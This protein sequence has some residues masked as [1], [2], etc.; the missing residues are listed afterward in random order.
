VNHHI[1]FFIIIKMD[2]ITHYHNLIKNQDY[3]HKLPLYNQSI[4][5][6]LKLR[7]LFIKDRENENLYNDKYTGLIDVFEYHDTFEILPLSQ[8]ETTQSVIL[9]K[10]MELIE[11]GTS[12]ISTK[13][14]FLDN[15][16]IFTE[17]LLTCLDW[18]N[19]L[20]AGGSA[21]AML[22]KL[23]SNV[24]TDEQKRKYYHDTKYS[25]SDI[26]LYIYGLDEYHATQKL[27][28][29]YEDIKKVLS[30]ECVCIRSARAITIVSQYPYR[31]IQIVIRLFK[32]PAEVLHSFDVDSCSVGFDGRDV[33]CTP[34]AHYAITTKRNTVDMTRRSIAYEFRLKKYN[35]RGYGVVV[36]GFDRAKVNYRIFSKSP[37]Q[38]AG[39]A[40]LLILENIDNDAKHNLYRDVLNMHQC[41][42]YKNLALKSKYEV[43][44]YS[45][46]FLP[47]GQKWNAKTIAEHMKQKNVILNK[48]EKDKNDKK[49]KIPEHLCFV[50]TMYQ[51]VKDNNIKKPEFDDPLQLQR[52]LSK[53]VC[54]R[55]K[56][57]ESFDLNANLLGSFSTIN[58]NIDEW[59][60]DAYGIVATDEL[61]EYICQKDLAQALVLIIEIEE[62]DP[63]NGLE[64]LLNSRDLANRNPLH[65]AIGMNDFE[66]CKLLLES[67]ADPLGTGKLY[68]TA[69]HKACEGGNLEIVKLLLEYCKEIPDFNPNMRDS[70]G[71]SPTMYTIMYGHLDCFQYLYENV[72]K[73]GSSLVWVFKLDKTKSYRALEMCL[74]YKR[75]DIAQ[76]L[77][78]NGYDKDD[79]YYHDLKVLN[80]QEKMRNHIMKQAILHWDM[81]FIKLLLDTHGYET[82]KTHMTCEGALINKIEKSKNEEQIKYLIDMVAYLATLNKTQEHLTHL[83]HL[84][85]K[86]NNITYIKYLVEDKHVDV[87]NALSN[88]AALDLVLDKMNNIHILQTQNDI[89]NC[90]HKITM[91]GNKKLINNKWAVS[92]DMFSAEFALDEENEWQ[93]TKYKITEDEAKAESYE[94]VFSELEKLQAYLISFN[95]KTYN[96]INHI[97]TTTEVKMTTINKVNFNVPVDVVQFKDLDKNIMYKTSKYIE[98][99]TAIKNGDVNT[100]I[101]LTIGA[102]KH[103]ALHL[104]VVTNN[105]NLSP[106]YI[107]LLY[108][109]NMVSEI[110]KIMEFQYIKPKP[111]K[112]K[113]MLNS[114]KRI[115]MN[116]NKLN[117]KDTEEV[118][119]NETLYE[120]Q[121]D[122][123]NELAISKYSLDDLL[124]KYNIVEYFST[125][126]HALKI[127]L[128]LNSKVIND[129][130]YNR[131]EQLIRKTTGNLNC[132]SLILNH[133]SKLLDEE[134]KLNLHVQFIN[135]LIVNE[136]SVELYH[137][138]LNVCENHWAS[139]TIAYPLRLFSEKETV[140]HHIA[141]NDYSLERIHHN[142]TDLIKEI[143]NLN[144]DC[145]NYLDE[146][147]R[148]PIMRAAI[149]NYKVF[150]IL[151]ELQYV[152]YNDPKIITDMKRLYENKYYMLH[153]VIYH[154]NTKT[155]NK[156]IEVL[157]ERILEIIDQQTED[158]LQTPLMIGIKQMNITM[159]N[160]LIE[161]GTIQDCVDIFGNTAL[162]YAMHYSAFPIVK[163]LM[164]HGKE[165]FFRMTPQDYIINMMRS[166]FHH[167]R[168]DKVSK[169]LNPKQ[170]Y[171]IIG[172]YNTFIHKKE[173][174]REFTADGHIMKVNDFIMSKLK[175]I[176]NGE[177]PE[178]LKL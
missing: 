110:K 146:S 55:L 47:W 166:I 124:Q 123:T 32:S 92:T 74:L 39:L 148:T 67:G 153:K 48:D 157:G 115:Y 64:R 91:D 158:K 76:Y 63:E 154:N 36:P 50:G 17:G 1:L 79:Y 93:L 160:K 130:V 103:E 14:E 117:E 25:K 43:S 143:I 72:V 8:E 170:L 65:L 94:K 155:F 98:L 73:N 128:E 57:Y 27:Y 168:N 141:M 101:A 4:Q 16:E 52:Y 172:I 144:P 118:V 177:I 34:R 46:I 44:D 81:N 161:L 12:A 152:D 20:L 26:D 59:Y 60:N 125:N 137:Y 165:N 176:T 109:I 159:A 97:M 171:F 151:L 42:M 68:K 100:L 150:K 66:M 28:Q 135:R 6:D 139:E 19:V 89:D 15:F 99:Y 18:N 136:N 62:K 78:N 102:N 106:L 156:I 9:A 104:C 147:N 10:D 75:Y 77:L 134:H 23:P 175:K 7:E 21:L 33:W 3:D 51:V 145:V 149:Y 80:K 138:F 88:K 40:R 111:K 22:T 162:H 133:Y 69:Y 86:N 49:D 45:L 29:I 116:N 114:K 122:E 83:L 90:I 120:E 30:C 121:P 107:A 140:L 167:I 112:E 85:V 24:Q 174:Q 173:I 132:L 131:I 126:Y 84:F 5:H 108:N 56:W 37:T 163:N 41:T 71:L 169:A 127:L 178:S 105:N 129:R 11:V 35:E 38:V 61:C 58:T 70:Y 95:A 164:M 113:K 54:G 31:H 13:E 96:D 119:E 87:N 142:Y 53:F 2:Y 82:Y